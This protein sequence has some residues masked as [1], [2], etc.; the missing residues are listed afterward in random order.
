MLLVFLKELMMKSSSVIYF[1]WFRLCGLSALI[2]LAFLISLCNVVCTMLYTFYVCVI[3]SL[4]YHFLVQ[5]MCMRVCDKI[6]PFSF[7][8]ARWYTLMFTYIVCAHVCVCVCVYM[9]KCYT[10]QLNCCGIW[11]FPWTL[12]ALRNIEFASFL[13]WYVAVELHDPAYAKRFYCTHEILE[14]NM[15]KVWD[16]KPSFFECYVYSDQDKYHIG[17]C[18]YYQDM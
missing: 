17:F 4:L 7:P 5:R 18:F 6:L 16:H 1:N 3:A 11:E 2:N 8:C 14:E 15:M 12:T 9:F 10:L 13:R